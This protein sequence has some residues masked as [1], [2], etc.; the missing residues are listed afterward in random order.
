MAVVQTGSCSSNFTPSL[1]TSICCKRGPR[2]TQKKKVS[3][4]YRSS[5]VMQRIK[6][7]TAAPWVA[8]E[9]WVRSSA[10]CS[11]LRIQCYHSIGFV[12]WPGN[13]HVPLVQPKKNSQYRESPPPGACVRL[14]LSPLFAAPGGQCR[15]LFREMAGSGILGVSVPESWLPPSIFLL[16]PQAH[17]L[18]LT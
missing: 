13:F 10:L 8:M 12:P 2:K 16:R 1:G 7:P 17:L 14:P 6:D 4:W 15:V 5:A 18:V 11:R 9:P 3:S